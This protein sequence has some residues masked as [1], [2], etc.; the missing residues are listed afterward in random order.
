MEGDGV[1]TAILAPGLVGLTLG[2][3]APATPTM[4]AAAV[5]EAAETHLHAG[6]D[7]VVI[8][9][10]TWQPGLARS[11]AMAVAAV[12][13]PRVARLRVDLPPLAA[14]LL[15]GQLAWLGQTLPTPGTLFACAGH[16]VDSLLVAAWTRDVANLERPAPSVGQHLRSLI[17]GAA[18][19]VTIRPSPGMHQVQP[20]VL[21]AAGWRSGGTTVLM[22]SGDDDHRRIL[23]STEITSVGAEHIVELSPPALTDAYFGTN[24]VCEIVGTSVDLQT[25]AGRAARTPTWA[26]RWCGLYVVAGRCPFC[27]SE[28]GCAG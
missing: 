12:G 28:L 18:F 11:C 6:N 3:P 4:D 5:A 26:C 16:L 2:G 25:L 17:P 19:W 15:A 1:A 24:K 7:A 14:S 8:L 22:I 10:P 20:G 21:H 23:R 27:R 9:E 13:S